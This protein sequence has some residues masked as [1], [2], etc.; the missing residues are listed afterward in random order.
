MHLSWFLCSSAH[1]PLWDYLLKL[2]DSGFCTLLY[3]YRRF[4]RDNTC[5]FLR[6]D[7]LR[8]VSLPPTVTI[9]HLRP[10]AAC[11]L[12]ENFQTTLSLSLVTSSHNL[13]I[14]F[15]RKIYL[16]NTFSLEDT[17]SSYVQLVPLEWASTFGRSFR[18]LRRRGT[19]NM[20]PFLNETNFFSLI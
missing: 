1:H 4:K 3:N 2:L 17:L 14:K 7:Y 13:S 8:C 9:H 12:P 10:E 6:E 19:K 15:Q 18:F 16:L 5:L 20:L 11:S